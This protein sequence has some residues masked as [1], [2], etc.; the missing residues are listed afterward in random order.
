MPKR[1]PDLSKATISLNDYLVSIKDNVNRACYYDPTN[2]N[3]VLFNKEINPGA[4]A[5]FTIFGILPLYYSLVQLTIFVLCDFF[6]GFD[7]ST[8]KGNKNISVVVI[9]VWFSIVPFIILFPLY[10]VFNILECLIFSILFLCAGVIAIVWRFR[11]N[12]K[13][14]EVTM[15]MPT[16]GPEGPEGPNDQIPI[17]D[18]V[19]TELEAGPV[20]TYTASAPAYNPAYTNEE[21]KEI[22]VAVAYV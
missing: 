4:T 18:V 15:P 16:Q 17:A 5:I 11:D 9:V 22:P 12:C 21:N 7:I 14:K 20:A 13:K 6:E 3:L 19:N 10:M 2:V 1:Y 8:S